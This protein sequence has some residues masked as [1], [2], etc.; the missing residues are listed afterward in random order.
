MPLSKRQKVISWTLQRGVAGI[1]FQTLCFKFTGAPESVY[2]FT[3]L[4]LEPWGR[5]TSGLLE[6]L[7]VVLLLTQRAVLLGA[8]LS[9]GIISLALGCHL[10]RLGIVV[11][12]DGGLLFGLVAAVFA[13]SLALIVIRRCQIPVLRYLLVAIAGP[14][15]SIESKAQTLCANHER[16][17]S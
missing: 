16:S 2:I 5:I 3:K 11:Q 10:T 8:L 4:G 7:A 14:C 15:P 9:L 6:L 13:G 1:L 12:N 17:T